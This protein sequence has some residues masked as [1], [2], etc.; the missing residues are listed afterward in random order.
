M[1]YSKF[2]FRPGKGTTDAIFI[3]RKLIESTKFLTISTLLIDLKAAL[4]TI[5]REALWKMLLKIGIP[6]K[7][8]ETIKYF[9]DKI[10]CSIIDGGELTGC[11]ISP[12]LFNIFLEH[13]M[14]GV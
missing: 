4:D 7:L 3:T 6:N 14:K 2:L 11:I 5:L 13:L 1:R 9:Y 12:S 10:K 8:V